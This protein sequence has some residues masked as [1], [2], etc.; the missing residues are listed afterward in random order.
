MKRSVLLATTILIIFSTAASAQNDSN[1]IKLKGIFLQI[2]ANSYHTSYPNNNEV[3]RKLNP[4]FKYFD[5]DSIVFREQN[6]YDETM[7][8]FGQLGLQ[9][10]KPTKRDG[11]TSVFSVGFSV[12][13]ANPYNRSFINEES[14]AVD[15]L[16]SSS[17]GA[18]IIL[19]STVTRQYFLNYFHERFYLNLGYAIQY[20]INKQWNVSAGVELMAGLILFSR[21]NSSYFVSA[22]VER[23]PGSSEYYP[24]ENETSFY[25]YQN[26]KGST[27]AL[28][29]PLS[30]NHK[31]SANEENFWYRMYLGVQVRPSIIAVNVPELGNQT[32]FGSFYSAKI[33]YGF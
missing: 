27:F 25:E 19:D 10:E 16:T 26:E 3:I 23:I 22:E 31:L 2:G 32:N 15:T 8:S 9:F 21:T 28:G 5:N 14:Y 4:N 30:V 33:M 11:L 1:K 7:T 24:I 20:E 13:P 6:T 12:T 18:S 29:L 17:T